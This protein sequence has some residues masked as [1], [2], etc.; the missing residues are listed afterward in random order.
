[1][2]KYLVFLLVLF[3]LN[4][5][6]QSCPD[7]PNLQD[8]E[9]VCDYE[10][11]INLDN[12]V[13]P[14]TGEWS[15]TP[16]DGN[17]FVYLGWLYYQQA[18]PGDYTLSLDVNNAA[19]GCPT[20][21]QFSVQLITT[22]LVWP[23][24][25]PICPGESFYVGDVGLTEEGFHEV[26]LPGELCDSLVQVILMHDDSV[27][28]EEDD[29]N[30]EL[31]TQPDEEDNQSEEEEDDG[32]N[33]EGGANSGIGLDTENSSSSEDET[34]HEESDESSNEP[35]LGGT[36]EIPEVMS[37]EMLFPTAFSPDNNGINDSFGLVNTDVNV[38]AYSIRVFDRWGSEVYF[39]EDPYER[40]FG[41]CRGKEVP[42]GA[43]AVIAKGIAPDGEEM[44]HK[45]V[46]TLLR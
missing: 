19:E 41:I 44:W 26:Y 42:N 3:S 20:N 40:W 29:S 22:A 24:P 27:C 36:I 15:V 45:G 18:S 14:L 13:L 17:V 2:K 35:E 31:S 32:S 21:Y 43:Y 1:M 7:V 11:P 33:G 25:Q 8:Y 16:E 12:A 9:V 30:P 4:S 5:L 37:N 38:T 28:F 10:D 6:S 46:I 23:V 39:S 34:N